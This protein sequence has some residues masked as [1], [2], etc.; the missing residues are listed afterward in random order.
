MTA[1]PSSI[2]SGPFASD[3]QRRALAEYQIR[4]IKYSA[5]GTGPINTTPGRTR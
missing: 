2:T 1:K 3:V 5:G 4:R